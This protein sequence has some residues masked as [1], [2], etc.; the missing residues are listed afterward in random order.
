MVRP[1]KKTLINS[2]VTMKK[3]V[4]N[5]LMASISTFFFKSEITAALLNYRTQMRNQYISS[6]TTELH[7]DWLGWHYACLMAKL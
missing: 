7:I 4:N 5:K 2:S 1:K 6:L 3:S